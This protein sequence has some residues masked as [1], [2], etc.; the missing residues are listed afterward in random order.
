MWQ[1]QQRKREGGL[2]F[3]PSLLLFLGLYLTG[4]RSSEREEE[5]QKQKRRLPPVGSTLLLN[6]AF[7]LS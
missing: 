6:L 5:G 7:L 1:L 3:L 2:A 4:S